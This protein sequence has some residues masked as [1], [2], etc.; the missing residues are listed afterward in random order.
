MNFK[1]TEILVLIVS[2]WSRN[3][4]CGS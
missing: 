1:K 3:D 4:L 2:K